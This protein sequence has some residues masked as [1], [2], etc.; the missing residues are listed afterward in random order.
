MKYADINRRFTEIVA[1]Y[2]KA[3]YTIN[4]AT[5]G[6]SQ[7]EVAHIDL[8]NG[9]SVT[10]ILLQHFF[11]KDDFYND[12]YEIV[13]GSTRNAVRV[14]QPP[15][16]CA[17]T[18]WNTR[19]DVIYREEFY[20]IGKRRGYAVWFGTRDDAVA[21][22]NTRTNRSVQRYYANPSHDN[23]MTGNAIRIA[24]KYIRRVTGIKH[25]NRAKL[26]VYH[27]IR[28]RTDEPLRGHVC[29][30]YTVIYNGKSYILH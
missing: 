25:P 15:E 20:E 26:S 6:G 5:M 14:D 2:L 11:C 17:G 13:V 9:D 22:R 21:A 4:T 24:E 1:G 28:V 19:L 23:A 10:R 27:A 7:S 18:I 12:G 8:S 3:G 30:Q 29:G 16:N